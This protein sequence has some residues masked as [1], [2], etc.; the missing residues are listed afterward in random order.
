MGCVG[1]NIAFLSQ[2]SHDGGTKQSYFTLQ[3]SKQRK[4]YVLVGLSRNRTH[5]HTILS[6]IYRK[7]LVHMIMEADK[8]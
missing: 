8:Y 2:A 6:Y 5:T 1:G 3:V 4:Q 7:E